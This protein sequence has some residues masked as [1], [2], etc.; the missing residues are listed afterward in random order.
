MFPQDSCYC[1]GVL[2]VV[3]NGCCPAAVVVSDTP[4]KPQVTRAEN[5]Y[6]VVAPKVLRPNGEYHVAVSTQAVSEA[7]QVSV[8]VGGKQDSGGE[9]RTKQLLSVDPFSTRIVKLDIGDLGP[10]QYNLTVKGSGSLNFYNSTGLVYVH[11]SY[12]VFIQLDKAIY[13]PGDLVRFRA[14]VLNS[15][16]KPSVTGAL[17]IFITDGKGNRIKQWTRALTTRGVFSADLQLSKSPVLGDWNITIN[18]LDQKFTKRFTVAEYVLPKFEVNVNVPPHATFKDSKVVISVNAKYTYG[19]PVKGEATI[20][21][22]PTIFSGVIQPLFQTPVRKVVPIDGKTVIEFDVVK[23]LQLTDEYERNIHFDVAVEEALTGRRQNNTG[24]VVF[25]KHKYKMDLIKSSEYFK[26]G[27]KYTAYM[28]LAHHDGTPV[29]DNNNMVQVRHGFSYDESKYEANQYKLDRNGMIKLVYYPPANE[30]VTTLG[31]EAEYLD[32]KEWFSTISASESPSNSFIQ[33]ALLTQ[34]P[35]VN[36]DVELEINSTAPL[37][38]ISYQVLGRGDVIMADT[39]TVPGNKMS[40]VIRFLATYAMAPTAHVI[41]QYV[42]EDGEVVADGLD[43]ELEGG[44]QNFVSANVS[45]DETEPGSNIQINLEAKPNSYIGLLAVDQKVLLLKTGNDIGKEDVMRELRSYDETDTSKLPLVENL[46]ERYPGSFTAQATFEKAGAIVMTNGY[47]HERN[48]WVFYK[49]LNDPPDDMLDGEEQL[50]SQVTTSVTQLTVRKHFP[51]TWLFQMEETGFDGKVMVNE[52]VPD[53]ITSWVLSAFSVDSLYGLGL[54]D[55]PKK[56]RVFRPF[57][58]SL[59]LPYSVMRGEVVAIP[60]V[61]FNYLSQDLVADV[62]L[63]NVG[64]FDFADFSNEVDAAPQPKFEVF[65]RK[66]L[67]IKANSGSTTTF[68][69]TPKELGYIGIKVTATSNLA[70]DSMEGKLLVKPEGETQ[71]KNKAIFVDLRKN[72]TFSVNVTLDMPKNIVP[73]S[74]HV[75]VSAVGDLLGPSIPNLANLI[76]MPFGC[77]EQNMLN[78]VPNIVVLEYLKKTYQLTDAIE[79]KASRYLETGY[80]QELTYRRPDGSFSAFGTTD[81]NGS[82]WLT[83]F[84]AKSFRQAASHTTIDESVILEALA[85]LSSNQ[86]VNGSFP[87][88]GKVSHADMQGGAAKGLALTAYTLVAFLE[89]SRATP[90]YR[91]TINKAVDYIVK[92]LAGTEDAYAIAI[93]SYALHLAQHPVKDVAFNLLESKAHN[94]DGK[95]WWKRAERPEDKKNPWAQVPNSVDVEMTS[96]ALLSYLDRGLVEDTLPILT[97]LVTQQNDQGGFASTQDTVIGLY[98]LAQLAEK[99]LARNNDISISFKYLNGQSSEMSV[100]RLNN[101][102]LQKNELP[103]KTRAVNMTATGSGFA[104]VYIS[105]QYN[106]NVTGAW[107]MFTLD[108]QVDK[109]SDSN[110]LQLSICSGFIGEGDSNMAVMEVS[111]PSGFTVDSDALPSL[112]VSQN[113]KRVETK[114]GNTMVVLYFDKMSKKELCPTVSAFR[115]HKVAQQKPVPVSIYDYYDQSRRARMFYEPRV[116]TLCDICEGEDCS[117]VCTSQPG[118]QDSDKPSA[119]ARLLPAVFLLVTVVLGSLLHH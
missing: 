105:Y 113:V 96:Y 9:F 19:K 49:S 11:K 117:K 74:E 107:P 23:E 93:C 85:W 94:E 97:W 89:N 62:T 45:P 36:K 69:I 98:A 47:V 90:L 46:R 41:V 8:E 13:K 86:A 118:Y 17:E 12:S 10:G 75:E 101:M 110:H 2:A 1:C 32:I 20:T 50:L 52:K 29:T 34:N 81:P 104:V 44:L 58:I 14:I 67:T 79:A 66:K 37:R 103:K 65:R 92:N 63:E 42:R 83:A 55:M 77:G 91:N 33:A 114:N 84:V 56:L 54:M 109:N 28:K 88:V 82:T 115:T 108:P 48:P 15:H 59:D 119:S 7:T 53:S 106:I 27:L 57:F 43:L 116:A 3:Y 111:L 6:T 22:Y 73:G 39:I 21:A 61:V 51:E 100:N 68:V 31:I 64:Q 16:L 72:K 76:K 30:N 78:F 60:V 95:K 38:Y 35:K 25:H 70:G 71:Y 87:E 80:Q 18:V 24:S 112:Q 99:V 40:T 5:Y 26:P 4:V 102:I